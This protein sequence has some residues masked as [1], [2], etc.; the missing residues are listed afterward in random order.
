ME[1]LMFRKVIIEMSYTNIL[2]YE[3]H[4][5]TEVGIKK[6]YKIYHQSM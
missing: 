1:W 5:S 6:N 3:V 4:G 2:M